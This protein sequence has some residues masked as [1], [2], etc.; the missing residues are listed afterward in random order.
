[1][2]KIAILLLITISYLTARA[3]Q[4]PFQLPPELM[5]EYGVIAPICFNEF[6]DMS[7]ARATLNLKTNPCIRYKQPYNEYALKNGLIGYDLKTDEPSMKPP[8]IFYRY[9]GKLSANNQSDYVF[10]ISWSGGGTGSFT[11]L[12]TMT[13]KHHVLSVKRTIATGDRCNGGVKEASIRDNHLFFNVNMTPHTLYTLN[14]NAIKQ[15]DQAWLPDCAICCVGTLNYQDD[16]LIGAALDGQLPEAAEDDRK[17]QCF[18]HIIN[19]Y[20]EKGTASL[21][22]SQLSRVQGDIHTRCLKK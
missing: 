14:N 7:G 13:L 22:P 12:M 6:T 3:E 19:S 16:K 9:I 17:L 18:N 15:D 21:T 1:M 11:Q 2:H 4:V 8:A 20:A 10:L 5:T